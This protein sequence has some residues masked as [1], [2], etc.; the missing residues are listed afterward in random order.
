MDNQDES[1]DN[2]FIRHKEE[3]F[4]NNFLNNSNDFIN[5]NESEVNSSLVLSESEKYDI[6]IYNVLENKSSNRNEYS[7]QV[8]NEEIKEDESTKIN[9]DLIVEIK[10][11]FP[12]QYFFVY[13]LNFILNILNIPNEIKEKFIRTEQTEEIEKKMSDEYVYQKQKRILPSNVH[14][15]MCIAIIHYLFS[16]KI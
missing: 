1:I 14:S 12:N 6:V 11:E 10:N 2:S 16:P 9:S 15:S 5:E 3:I 4:K 8:L 13:L 7:M